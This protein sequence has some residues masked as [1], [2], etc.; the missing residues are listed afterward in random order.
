MEKAHL[1]PEAHFFHGKQ[2]ENLP[3]LLWKEQYGLCKLAPEILHCV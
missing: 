1:D 2:W 3:Y